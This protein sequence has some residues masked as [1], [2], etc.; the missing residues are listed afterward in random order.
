MP[1]IEQPLEL[2][3]GEK[4]ILKRLGKAPLG[5][6]WGRNGW[7]AEY[8]PKPA[9]RSDFDSLC[10]RNPPLVDIKAALL[11]LVDATAN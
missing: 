10:K 6:R 11:H 5:L 8:L 3:D 7:C 2:T 1:K 9:K 4:A